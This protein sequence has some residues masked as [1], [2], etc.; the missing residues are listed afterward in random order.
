MYFGAR[1]NANTAI[2]CNSMRLTTIQSLL[3]ILVIILITSCSGQSLSG[4]WKLRQVDM[5]DVP[6]Q[7]KQFTLDLT[8]P[9]KMKTDLYEASLLKEQGLKTDSINALNDEIDDMVTTVDVS[10]MKAEIEKFVTSAINTSLT[11]RSDNKFYMKSNGLIV[12]TAAPGWHFGDTLQG[13]WIKNKDTLVL[14]IGDNKQDY[15]WK[16]KILQVTNKD[17]RIQEIFDGFEGRGN[18]LGFIRQ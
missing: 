13:K 16:F 10:T 12:P 15:T 7:R 17:L 6:N 8:K 1:K 14:S 3:L 18:E 9:E 4:Q 2:A 5:M 11:L